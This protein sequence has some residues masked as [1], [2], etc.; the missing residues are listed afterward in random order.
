MQLDCQFMKGQEMF[1]S[2]CGSCREIKLLD[3]IMNV[4]ELVVKK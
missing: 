4:M 2:E 3:Q 1:L